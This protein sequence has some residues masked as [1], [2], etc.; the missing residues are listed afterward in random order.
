[1]LQICVNLPENGTV[2]PNIRYYAILKEQ[3]ISRKD[4]PQIEYHQHRCR[5]FRNR[6]FDSNAGHLGPTPAK[7]SEGV[8]T[9]LIQ[10]RQRVIT[11]GLTWIYAGIFFGLIAFII[12]VI[13]FDGSLNEIAANVAKISFLT[14]LLMGL[15]SIAESTFALV[16]KWVRGKTHDEKKGIS[17]AEYKRA[18]KSMAAAAIG[19]KKA[20]EIMT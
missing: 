8:S 4:L 7:Y 15:T 19:V 11:I 13:G 10:A 14:A 1:M 17:I 20:L 12:T 5:S 2:L 3:N 18:F 16:T 9:E 6:D